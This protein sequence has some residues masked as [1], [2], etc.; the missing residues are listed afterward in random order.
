MQYVA[1]SGFNW[2]G[3]VKRDDSQDTW[4]LEWQ[5][6]SLRPYAF[7]KNDEI[8]DP[9][10]KDY[11][12]QKDDT[13]WRKNIEDFFR[14]SKGNKAEWEYQNATGS[15]LLKLNYAEQNI[16][17]KV[18]LDRSAVWHYPVLT[19]I[20]VSKQTIPPDVIFYDVKYK[21]DVDIGTGLDRIASLPSGCPY[22]FSEDEEWKWL[23]VGDTLTETRTKSDVT[24][25]RR[26]VYQGVIEPDENF[27]GINKFDHSDL[28]KTRWKVAQ[29]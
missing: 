3:G 24:F 25:T 19:H 14:S 1:S 23:L 28:E 21:D 11:Q 17:K 2:S 12:E 9:E 5:P 15:K 29:I 13:A 4:Q 26:Q 20:T 7:C 18:M 6:Y 8:Q 16:A 27:Y 22:T 10:A